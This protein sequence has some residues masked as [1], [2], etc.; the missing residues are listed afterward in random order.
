MKNSTL[1]HYGLD[2]AKATLRLSGPGLPGCDLPNT[3]AGHQALLNLLPPSAHPVCEAPGG[4]ERAVV[5]ALQQAARKVSVVNPRRARAAAEGA[6]QR[7][8]SDAL[9]A[10]ELAAYGT[11]FQPTPT[12][13]LSP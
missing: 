7:A 11:R 8:K 2:V 12:L 13:V 5:A 6:G 10:A 3:P 4:Y 1:T 9:D